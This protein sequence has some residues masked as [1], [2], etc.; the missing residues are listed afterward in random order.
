MAR[1]GD[2]RRH[3]TQIHHLLAYGTKGTPHTNDVALTEGGP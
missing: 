3:S 1:A 2:G